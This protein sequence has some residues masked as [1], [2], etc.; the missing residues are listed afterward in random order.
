[1]LPPT[2]KNMLERPIHE[3]CVR[4]DDAYRQAALNAQKVGA[5]DERQASAEASPLRE[6]GIAL[7][8]AL[9]ESTDLSSDSPSCS[10]E[11]Q[12]AAPRAGTVARPLSRSRRPRTDTTPASGTL[13]HFGVAGAQTSVPSSIRA[14]CASRVWPMNP[15]IRAIAIRPSVLLVL[16]P[17][18]FRWKAS[19][20]RAAPRWS[21][22][23]VPRPPVRDQ[24]QVD[25][26]LDE[27]AL[28]RRAPASSSSAG[29]AVVAQCSGDAR[30][31]SSDL[32]H[33]SS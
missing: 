10:D 6:I 14:S 19:P 25:H 13:A 18:A 17:I 31:R 15:T 28:E 27:Q 23:R 11:V 30:A 9:L 1:M 5:P 8:A 33:R 26:A 3:L 20:R 4:A 24:R 21:R 7:K 12:G 16:R 2:L 32:S 29:S 22:S